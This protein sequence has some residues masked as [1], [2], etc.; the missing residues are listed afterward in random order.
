[1]NNVANDLIYLSILK[2]FKVLKLLKKF[3]KTFLECGRTA[4]PRAI[5]RIV[6]GNSARA[7]SWPWMVSLYREL[8]RFMRY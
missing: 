2:Q 8:L 1:M 5:L 3:S 4:F 7:H 6:G